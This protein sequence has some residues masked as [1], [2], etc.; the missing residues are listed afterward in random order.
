MQTLSQIQNP[1]H[2]IEKLPLHD[3]LGK[4]FETT[5]GK[6]NRVMNRHAAF[7]LFFSLLCLAE[8]AAF[9]FFF[10]LLSH[11]LI[12]AASL[13]LLFF[14]FFAYF[15]LRI[16]FQTKKFEQFKGIGQEYL[17][18]CRSLLN[19]QEGISENHIAL[20]NACCKLANRLHAKEYD[21]YR[22]PAFLGFLA[23]CMEKISCWMH[24]EEVHFL[25]EMMLE[26]AVDEQVRHVKSQPTSL[27]AHAALANAYADAFR[28]LCRPAQTRWI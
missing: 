27:E 21:F 18:S 9:G 13:S 23:P 7:N 11:S 1:V 14:S 24:W 2:Y 5:L 17:N 15:T 25:K 3:Q 10:A 28:T 6:F 12:L 22:P 8:F 4:T 19:Y 26:S 16:Y 20:A